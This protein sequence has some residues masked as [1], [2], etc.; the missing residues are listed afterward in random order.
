METSTNFTVSNKL[1][2]V[3]NLH[4]VFWLFKDMSWCMLWRELGVIMIF[5]TLFVSIYL[6]LK[7]RS[8]QSELFHNIS[9]TFW[10]LANSFWM[11]SEFYGFDE[12]AILLGLKG[13]EVAFVF[14]ILGVLILAW[15]YILIYPKNNK[16]KTT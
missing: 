2:K 5:P 12:K 4:I 8:H 7:T 16:A 1:R 3:E 13:N 9:I 10:I 6:T 11:I 15:Y 14:F